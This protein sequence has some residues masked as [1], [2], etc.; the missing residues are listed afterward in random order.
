MVSIL[1]FNIYQLIR[2]T[3]SLEPSPTFLLTIDVLVVR[4]TIDHRA[5]PFGVTRQ[6][7]PLP[8]SSFSPLNDVGI[9][10]FLHH[11]L[12][13]SESSEWCFSADPSQCL[14]FGS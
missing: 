6:N 1:K 5:E 3:R 4:V 14:S 13:R 12:S 8:T 11:E 2:Q 9:A 7:C 10:Q